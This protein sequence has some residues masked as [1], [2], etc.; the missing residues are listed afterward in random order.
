MSDFYKTYCRTMY[1]KKK[2]NG[3]RV[4]SAEDVAM[5]VKAGKITAEDYEKITGEKYEG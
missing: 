3:E 1:N 4:Y 2:A 5:F